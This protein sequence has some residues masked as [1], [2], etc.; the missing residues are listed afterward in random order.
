MRWRGLKAVSS[1]ARDLAGVARWASSCTVALLLVVVAGGSRAAAEA[2]PAITRGTLTLMS[3]APRGAYCGSFERPLDP[4]GERAGTLAVGFEYYPHSETGPSAGVLVATEGG[5]GFPARESRTDYLTLFRPL[6]RDHDVLI[7]DNRGTGSSGAVDCPSLQRADATFSIE[8]VAAC[9]ALLDRD[10]WLY[11]TAY[12]TDDLA[13][14]LDA[15]GIAAIDLYGDSYG[16]FTAQTFAVRHPDRLRT[17]V[18]DGAYPLTSVDGGWYPTYAPAMRDKF[19]TAC[20][21]S[22]ACRAVPG[23]SI[24]HI[25]PALELLRNAPVDVRAS[26]ADGRVVEMKA[27][28]AALA[29]AMFGAAPAL[30]TVREMDAAARSYAAGD[31]LPLLRLLAEAH[32]NVDSRDSTYDPRTFSSGVA[33]A[34]MCGDAPQIFDMTLPPEVRRIQRDAAIKAR[35][36]RY[37]DAFAPFTYAEYRSIPLDYA[38]IDECVLWPAVSAA[39]RA[40]I[41]VPPDAKFPDIP[42]LVLSGELDNMTTV[43]DG[44]EVAGNFKHA[45]QVILRNS[46]HVNALPRAR[47]ECG[48]M[49]VRRFIRDRVVADSCRDLVAPVRLVSRFAT[50][51][52]DLDPALPLEGSAATSHEL[53]LAAAAV[54]TLGDVIVRVNDNTSGHGNGLRGGSFLVSGSAQTRTVTLRRV[55]W[56][57]DTALDARLILHRSQGRIEAHVT[58]L[59]DTAPTDLRIRWTDRGDAPEATITG[60]IAGHRIRARIAAP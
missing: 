33:A 12:A 48:A 4:L 28:A 42:V 26:D 30:A 53:R 25:R 41:V 51:A 17:L 59:A 16:T 50:R 35:S 40:S 18:L 58:G 10:A 11:S 14:L 52:D 5:P 6:M 3:C 45:T 20:E 46:F 8:A 47:A 34:I 1:R 15:L 9:G 37:P 57:D 55:K 24:D 2:I 54:A 7:M 49:I 44:A 22:A 56:T 32:V 13:A 21:R 31:R 27:D 60:S 38:F 23:T 39:R 19:N 29:T 36:Q 43:K